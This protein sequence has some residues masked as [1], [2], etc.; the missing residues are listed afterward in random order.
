MKAKT[1]QILLMVIM[2]LVTTTSIQ[3]EEIKKTTVE[4]ERT[5]HK[6]MGLHAGISL[7]AVINLYGK[8]DCESDCFT[9]PPI[10]PGKI[11]LSVGY[12]FNPYI[13]LD[14]KLWTFWLFVWGVEIAPK[15]SL[16][17]S[18]VSPFVTAT[19]GVATVLGEGATYFGYG[20]GVDIHVSK[21][22]SFFGMA[23]WIGNPQQGV[24][25]RGVLPEFGVQFTF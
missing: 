25:V 5:T 21:R 15:F 19:Y 11:D 8:G 12:Q 3:A 24:N 14:A 17:D 7:N 22:T 4:F 10:L 2:I 20:G 6:K 18:M 23:R 9:V 1:K 16:T 13:S